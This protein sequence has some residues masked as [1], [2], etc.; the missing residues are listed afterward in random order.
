MLHFIF[1][2]ILSTGSVKYFHG[3][4]KFQD[5]IDVIIKHREDNF[6]VP[7]SEPHN[8]EIPELLDKNEYQVYTS[9]LFI[10]Q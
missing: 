6:F 7:L 10:K 4:A 8:A 3:K 1:R 2:S 5:L 9:E